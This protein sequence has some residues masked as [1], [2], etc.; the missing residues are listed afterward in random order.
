[1]SESGLRSLLESTLTKLRRTSVPQVPLLAF[2]GTTRGRPPVTAPFGQ[3]RG[4]W[5]TSYNEFAPEAVGWLLGTQPPEIWG[6]WTVFLSQTG[7]L[8]HVS[9]S[10]TAKPCLDNWIITHRDYGQLGSCGSPVPAHIRGVDSYRWA[11]VK[12][13]WTRHHFLELAYQGSTYA[14]GSS[15]ERMRLK[16]GIFN[17]AGRLYVHDGGLYSPLDRF[18]DEFVDR[19][20]I[21]PYERLS[22]SYQCCEYWRP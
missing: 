12:P 6:G 8:F 7:R 20:E 1:M 5:P 11:M 15:L 22:S 19:A 21:S 13:E 18:L 3:L 4:R 17:V 10:L 16:S 2:C 14:S 9:S